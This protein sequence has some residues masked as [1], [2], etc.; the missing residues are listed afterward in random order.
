M[1]SLDSAT[2]DRRLALRTLFTL[3]LMPADPT[4]HRTK[5]RLS[6]HATLGCASPDDEVKVGATLVRILLEAVTGAWSFS[7]LAPVALPAKRAY[8]RDV[9]KLWTY[10]MA[11]EGESHYSGDYCT[12]SAVLCGLEDS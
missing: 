5:N 1:R 9:R 6:R 11:S 3:L 7:S 2:T 8:V 12:A 4:V 10:E